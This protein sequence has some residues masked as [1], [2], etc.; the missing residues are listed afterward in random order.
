MTYQPAG[1]TGEMPNCDEWHTTVLCPSEFAGVGLVIHSNAKK[2][3]VG[4]Q[5]VCRKIAVR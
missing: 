5:L 3:I 1:S 2:S 4:L